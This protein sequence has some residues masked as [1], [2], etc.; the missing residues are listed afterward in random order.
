MAGHQLLLLILYKHQ[1]STF[2]AAYL[3][4][5]AARMLGDNITMQ[6]DISQ[7]CTH[8]PGFARFSAEEVCEDPH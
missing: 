7:V 6:M 8:A 4:T 3:Y 1:M 5:L 2:L